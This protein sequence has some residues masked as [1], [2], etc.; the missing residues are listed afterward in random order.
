MNTKRIGREP[1]PHIK[2][3]AIA[4]LMESIYCIVGLL[5]LISFAILT[6]LI[7]L[8]FLIKDTLYDS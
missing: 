8:F 7:G 3:G 2:N 4:G 6:P 1:F 5:G